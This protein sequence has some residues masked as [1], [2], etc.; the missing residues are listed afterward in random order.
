[1][2]NLPG[3]AMAF[4]IQQIFLSQSRMGKR[5]LPQRITIP[6]WHRHA[7]E[8]QNITSPFIGNIYGMGCLP[9]HQ[10]MRVY[11]STL[12]VCHLRRVSRRKAVGQATSHWEGASSYPPNAVLLASSWEPRGRGALPS[13]T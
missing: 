2:A 5:L 3:Y 11:S 1:M 12:W 8:P 4:F 9:G 7:G 10:R 6:F 13:R